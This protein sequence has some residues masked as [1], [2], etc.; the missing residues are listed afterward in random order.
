MSKVQGPSESG[1]RKGMTQ[2]IDFDI[3]LGKKLRRRWNYSK[4]GEEQK[5]N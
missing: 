1:I 5:P 2:N 4:E 3:G